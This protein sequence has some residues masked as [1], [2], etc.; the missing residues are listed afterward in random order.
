MKKCAV[1][2]LLLL[3]LGAA[4]WADP[5][6]LSADGSIAPGKAVYD[7]TGVTFGSNVTFE[8]QFLDVTWT[9]GTA[10]LN[11]NG[12]ALINPFPDFNAYSGGP[13]ALMTG[14]IDTS[15]ISGQIGTLAFTADTFNVATNRVTILIQNVAVD[16]QVIAAEVPEPTTLLL[17][18]TGLGATVLRRKMFLR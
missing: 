10:N 14:T 12:K 15:G 9:S 3:L 6:I 13:T 17:V 2:A 16:G 4:A 8:Y 18:I 11:V 7:I 5:I 1:L